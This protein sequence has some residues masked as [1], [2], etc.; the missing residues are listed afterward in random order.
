M[1]P[2]DLADLELQLIDI[3][4]TQGL[5]VEEIRLIG[6]LGKGTRAT[7]FSVLIDG[8]YHVLKV[9]DS[10]DSLKA[11]LKNLRKVTP[12]DRFLFWWQER[13]E[14]DRKINLAI[15][16]VPEGTELSSGKLNDKT[17]Q[18]I[19]DR[20]TQL[21]SIRYRQRVSHSNLVQQLQRYKKPFLDHIALMSDRDPAPYMKLLDNLK[22]MLTKNPDLFRTN[23]SRIHGDLW[24][25]NV[26]VAKEDVYL[27]DWES[28]RRGDAAE[29]IAKLR[30]YIYGYRTPAVPTF[31]FDAPD[32]AVQVGE[33]VK[34]ITQQHETAL[35]DETLRE[36]LKFYLPLNC[37]QELAN[38]YMFGANTKRAMNR[39]VA[40]DAL[41]LFADPFA[42]APD[43]SSYGY[44][45]EIEAKR[46]RG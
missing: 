13:L 28:V 26:I 20:T 3:L 9:Y 35:G 31:F 33:L 37:I 10:S 21:H 19:A 44:F 30:V 38:R 5:P 39:M 17:M 12:K 6:L 25:P 40:D 34:T 15:I 11:E 43:L 23:K 41:A 1:P 7:A 45:D 24:W 32:H 46:F 22:T 42:P 29:D 8:D 14:D 27:I 4:T 16:E 2:L 18:I 36:R